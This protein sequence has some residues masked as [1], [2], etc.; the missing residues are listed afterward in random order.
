MWIDFEPVLGNSSQS[1][2]NL[3][4]IPWRLLDVNTTRF[5]DRMNAR[6]I[7]SVSN[8]HNFKLVKI[9]FKYTLFAKLLVIFQ[10]SEFSRQREHKTLIWSV[11]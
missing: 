7:L 2:L 4:F 1:L 3:I 9:S 6:L 10:V 5:F 11:S 8:I